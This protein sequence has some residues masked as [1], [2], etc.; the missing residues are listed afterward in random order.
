[1]HKDSSA[2]VGWATACVVQRGPQDISAPGLGLASVGVQANVVGMP[3]GNVLSLGDGGS[4]T[5]TFAQ[6]ISNGPG[7]DFAVFENGFN[8]TYLELAF[9]EVSSNGIDYV[10][11]PATSNT[12]TEAQ[13][14]GF[15]AVDATLIDN[16]AG[17][18]RAQFGTPFDLE[19][20]AGDPTI[21]VSAVTHVRLIDVVGCIQAVYATYDHLGRVVNDPWST[22]FASSGFDLDGVG[23]IHQLATDVTELPH[24]IRNVQVYP[25]PTE[26]LTGLHYTLDVPSQVAVSVR[27]VSGRYQVSIPVVNAPAGINVLQ[28]D[29]ERL[30]AGLYFVSITTNSGRVSLPVIRQ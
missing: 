20:L 4:A 10:R 21:D 8:D 3:N 2:F 27:D 30:P 17:K 7:W 26:G 25:N 19:E 6:P 5:L 23:V 18:Y 13:I 16:F 9:V 24:A 15:G 22:P 29:L 11:F 28:L 1:M 12:Q 14:D